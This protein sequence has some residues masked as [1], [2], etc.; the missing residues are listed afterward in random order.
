MKAPMGNL[1]D[2]LRIRVARM[3]ANAECEIAKRESIAIAD[4]AEDHAELAVGWRQIGL[5]ASRQLRAIA[6]FGIAGAKGLDL[7]AVALEPPA[8]LTKHLG[9]RAAAPHRVLGEGA[10]AEEDAGMTSP[11][12][13]VLPLA[14]CRQER[15]VLCLQG[16]DLLLGGVALAFGEHRFPGGVAGNHELVGVALLGDDEL[17]LEST[18]DP[19]VR[20]LLHRQNH[21]RPTGAHHDY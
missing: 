15:P 11:D 14:V 4:E 10:L 12:G 7:C 13:Q 20:R 21:R 8:C 2:G 19:D 17:T 16:R 9:S 3:M 1:V 6:M 18:A 5:E